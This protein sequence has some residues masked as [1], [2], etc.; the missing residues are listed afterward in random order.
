M[1]VSN[2]LWIFSNSWILDLSILLGPRPKH[3]ESPES[4][5]VQKEWEKS[6]Q[7]SLPLS[8]GNFLSGPGNLTL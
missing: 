5:H 6:K 8:M 3:L 2:L 1:C 4:T 7:T